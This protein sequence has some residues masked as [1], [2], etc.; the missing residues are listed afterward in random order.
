MQKDRIKILILAGGKG[1]RMESELP[2]VLVPLKG[3]PMVKHLLESIEKSEVAGNPTIV[4]GYKKEL[5]MENLGD[6]YD[7]AI[8][9]EQL[10]T[11]HA[12]LSAEKNVADADHILVLYGDNPFM[13]SETIKKIV[14]EHLKFGNKITMATTTLPDFD[15]WRSFFY[16]N[17]SRI[18]RDE[19]GK[20]LKSVEFKDA[21]EKEKEIME[22]NPCYF[23]FESK[24]LFKELKN[25]KN[26]N[27][28][29]EYYLTDLVKFAIN[30]GEKVESISIDPSEALAANSKEELRLL[31]DFD[32]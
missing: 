7:Y 5:V 2:K 12:V 21:N 11:G 20:I 16:K 3:K 14:S 1:K 25:L 32:V 24:W 9:E 19:K 8:Q 29:K 18:V 13:T 27:A 15:G 10:G 23:C 22:V 4:V 6:K 17:F 26:E 28:Q 31:E 30:K